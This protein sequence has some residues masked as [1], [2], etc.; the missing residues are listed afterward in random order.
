MLDPSNPSDDVQVAGSGRHIAGPAASRRAA[1]IKTM[2]APLRD[3]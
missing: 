1:A 3:S 2:A